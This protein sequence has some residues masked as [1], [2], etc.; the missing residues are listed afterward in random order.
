MIDCNDGCTG[1]K[2]R[3]GTLKD[4]SRICFDKFGKC[5]LFLWWKRAFIGY[6]FLDNTERVLFSDG[7]LRVWKNHIFETVLWRFNRDI[8]HRVFIWKQSRVYVSG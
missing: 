8:G 7:A 5:S 6:V 1:A 3:Y 2:Q 4:S